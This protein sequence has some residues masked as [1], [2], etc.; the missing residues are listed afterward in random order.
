MEPPKLLTSSSRQRKPRARKQSKTGCLICKRRKIK[1]GPI[2]R[3]C[4]CCIF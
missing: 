2:L 3:C 4:V 1:V